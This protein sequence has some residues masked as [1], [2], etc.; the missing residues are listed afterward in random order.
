MTTTITRIDATTTIAQALATSDHHERIE[1]IAAKRSPRAVG[2]F[3]TPTKANVRAK[4]ARIWAEEHGIDPA[5]VGTRP[6][7]YAAIRW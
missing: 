2:G 5:T 7:P 4:F 6:A 1:Y 3:F